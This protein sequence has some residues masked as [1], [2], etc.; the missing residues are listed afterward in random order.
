MDA[1]GTTAPD[2][3]P[4]LQ[5]LIEESRARLPDRLRERE[6][7]VD[8]IAAAGFLAAAVTMALAFEPS[9]PL[10]IGVAGVLVGSYAIASRVEFAMGSG[11]A[12]PTQL[13]FV[14]MLFLLPTAAVP[15]FVAAALVIARLPEYARGTVHMQRVVIRVAEAW[16]SIWPALVLSIAGVTTATLGDWPW[17]ALALAAQFGFD[18]ALT[19]ARLRATLGMRLR[20]LLEEM[21]AVYLVDVLLTPVGFLA[22]VAAEETSPYAVVCLLPLL[23]LMVVFAHE[24]AARIDNAVTLAAAYRGTAHLLGELLSNSHEYTGVHSESVVVLA[25]QVGESLGLD[26]AELREIEFG[27]LLHDVGK[28]AVPVEIINKPAPLT[29]EEQEL[30]R[31]HPVE[32]ARMLARIGGVLGEAGEVVHRHHENYDGTGYPG[33]LA[34]DQI[35]LA[36]R[37]IAC[38][39]A[40]TA[41]TTDRPYRSSIGT[42][43]AIAEL[44]AGS[45]TQFDPRVVEAV[46]RIVSDWE[47]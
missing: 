16:Y 36:S 25:H 5:R 46:I 8:L 27:A 39:D 26:D 12:V 17:L 18:L 13:F 45:G 7:A 10:E 28:M 32:G 14:P 4:V 1:L 38:C 24:R 23:G 3:D 43:R 22:A 2:S 31:T 29:A 42:D 47:D 9:R 6:R 34:G 33:G 35:P 11:W 37:V 44:R 30:V 41:M 20:P 19:A 15:L 40:F 21:R